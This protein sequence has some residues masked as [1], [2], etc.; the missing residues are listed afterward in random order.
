[1][2]L[3]KDALRQFKDSGCFKL[4]GVSIG[5]NELDA[6][7]RYVSQDN[8]S[9]IHPLQFQLTQVK[10]LPLYR[11]ELTLQKYSVLTGGVAREEL[12]PI[13][14]ESQPEPLLQPDDPVFRLLSHMS[15]SGKAQV[16]SMKAEGQALLLRLFE[17]VHW[18]V[19][20]LE[21]VVIVEGGQEHTLDFNFIAKL[22]STLLDYATRIK[23]LSLKHVELYGGLLI[24]LLPN[25]RTL[26]ILRLED[27]NQTEHFVSA[28]CGVLAKHPTLRELDFGES[29]L[30]AA[31]Y[32]RLFTLSYENYRIEKI[33]LHTPDDQGLRTK[34]QELIA[35][36]QKSG[37]ERFKT[38][39]ITPENLYHI[40]EVA[41]ESGPSPFLKLVLNK[42]EKLAI[43]Y[44]QN[45][46]TSEKLLQQ[47]PDVFRRHPEYVKQC[48]PLQL[49]IHHCL[50]NQTLGTKLFKKAFQL[51]NPQGMQ[52][53]LNAG[54]DLL[55]ETEEGQP[56]LAEWI[57]SDKELSMCEQVIV[58][59]IKKD[60]SVFVPFISRLSSY[61]KVDEGLR[62]IKRQLDHFL[63]TL[64]RQHQLPYLFKLI[65]GIGLEA[66]K[67]NWEK[68][69]RLVVTAAREGTKRDPVDYGSLSDLQGFIKTL[70]GE[71]EKAKH[72]WFRA[73]QFNQILAVLL[74]K[75]LES[76]EVYK[77]E[78]Y[79]NW[80]RGQQQR[81]S[82]KT[83]VIETLRQQLQTAEEEKSQLKAKLIAGEEK[84][85]L[86]EEKSKLREEQLKAEMEEKSN[87]REERSK[88]REE[89]LKIEME[90]FKAEIEHLT[91]LVQ[92]LLP[93]R[94][95]EQHNQEQ[96]TENEA[97]STFRFFKH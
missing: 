38:E 42:A 26:E 91:C 11:S 27:V 54:V 95:S 76:T 65:R 48:W 84:S 8:F 31:S 53:L 62:D 89:Q 56:S 52:L 64:L 61:H 40:A 22:Y 67:E 21:H 93:S 34:H 47:L 97:A 43:D 92:Q 39:H 74:K 2:Q 19:I 81:I 35:R 79:R 63:V 83:D 13:L 7:R 33:T 16:E 9:H 14:R 72:Q 28:L 60:L 12:P 96:T 75:L 55:K 50:G 45:P 70:L 69:L 85:K 29:C 41:L 24:W 88:L 30:Q 73:C 23:E 10:L 6:L 37:F 66:R 20:R 68:D 86:Q 59:H 82:G 90:K 77:E 58:E 32:Q 57:F 36:L 15:H 18:E 44:A 5:F 1:M 51:R 87:L 94:L 4:Q 80:E 78:L 49:D 46:P 3:F 71:V 17:L 25:A